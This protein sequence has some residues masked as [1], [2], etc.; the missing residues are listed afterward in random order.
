MRILSPLLPVFLA[1][2]FILAVRSKLRRCLS[3]QPCW[4]SPRAFAS[5]QS[6]LSQPLLKPIVPT[7]SPCY[8]PSSP[9]GNCSQV[10]AGY[11]DG[12]W[13]ASVPGS[14]QSPNW[15]TYEH[16]NTIDAC[17]LNVTVGDGTCK[18]GSVPTVGVDARVPGDVIAAVE[19]AKKWRLRV[20]VKSTGRVT[21]RFTSMSVAEH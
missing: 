3:T 6:N 20:V 11:N 17:Y 7:A 16:G 12:I 10:Q 15:E 8:P 19:F 21:T 2:Q 1:T 5:L 9:S 13:R 18:Q 14:M 4:P